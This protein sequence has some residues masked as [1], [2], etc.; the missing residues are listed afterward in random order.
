[1]FF[2]VLVKGSTG[3]AG[4]GTD[5]I[6]EITMVKAK[7]III[8]ELQFFIHHHGRTHITNNAHALHMRANHLLVQDIHIQPVFI[9]NN[10]CL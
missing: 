8:A 7:G 10:D 9:T 4:S 6:N 2:Q 1:M 5:K 3:A